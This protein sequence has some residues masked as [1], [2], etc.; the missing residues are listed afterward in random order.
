[1]RI[2]L[3]PTHKRCSELAYVTRKPLAGLPGVLQSV[4]LILAV[5]S[6]TGCKQKTT[7]PQTKHPI[8]SPATQPSVVTAQSQPATQPKTLPATQPATQPASRPSSIYDSKPPY[9]VKLYVRSPEDKQPGW[10]KVTALADTNSLATCKGTF[11]ERNRIVV[12]TDNVHQLRL[13]IG[14]LP[15]AARKRIVLRIDDQGIELS[16]KKRAF[17]FLERRSTGEWKVV[18]SGK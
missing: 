5:A 4:M 13:H 1:M 15:L 10:L 8:E 3:I 11:P 2:A 14:H 9:P 12:E 7:Q 6:L 18:K 16:H 17:V